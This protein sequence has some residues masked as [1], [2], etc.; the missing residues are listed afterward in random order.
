MDINLFYPEQSVLSLKHITSVSY[1]AHTGSAE[2][3]RLEM[4]SR[5]HFTLAVFFF[6]FKLISLVYHFYCFPQRADLSWMAN[7]RDKPGGWWNTRT[8]TMRCWGGRVVWS[9]ELSERKGEGFFFLM[10][11]DGSTEVGWLVGDA[12]VGFEK[13][14]R[15]S[16]STLDWHICQRAA[17]FELSTCL[18]RLLTL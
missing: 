4:N 14:R 2:F 9:S 11:K 17:A 7:I 6:F 10:R 15:H 16:V 5:D 3:S 1:P 12:G 18:P 8:H 13:E